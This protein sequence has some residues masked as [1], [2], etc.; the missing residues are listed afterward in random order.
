MSPTSSLANAYLHDYSRACE[1]LREMSKSIEATIKTLT[2]FEAELDQLKARAAEAKK[3]LIKSAG[4][5]ADAAR[6]ETI[7]RAQNMAEKNLAEAKAEAGK[8]VASIESA[9]QKSLQA[10]RWTMA[11][12]ADEA[13]QLVMKR[14]LGGGP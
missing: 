13:V 10:L 9:G 5:W 11:D 14:L 2:E 1:V 8:E 4:G 12:H 7:A 6:A 3:E